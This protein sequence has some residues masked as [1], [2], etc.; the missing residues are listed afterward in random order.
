MELYPNSNSTMVLSAKGMVFM[1]TLTIGLLKLIMFSLVR[2]LTFGIF[3][4]ESI[5]KKST[6]GWQRIEY[7]GVEKQ[8]E[9]MSRWDSSGGSGSVSFVNYLCISINKSLGALTIA[10]FSMKGYKALEKHLFKL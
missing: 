1:G 9:E 7:P 5:I 8:R 4:F 6:K 2:Q 3:N 10:L